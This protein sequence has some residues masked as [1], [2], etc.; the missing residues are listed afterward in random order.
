MEF[1]GIGNTPFRSRIYKLQA[2]VEPLVFRPFSV[3]INV[4]VD[5]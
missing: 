3:Y 1:V 4:S 2:L 5:L